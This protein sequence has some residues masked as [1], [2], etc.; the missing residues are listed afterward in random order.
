[1]FE[2]LKKS[3][4]AQQVFTDA[5]Q[6]AS[7]HL[8]A[9]YTLRAVYVHCQETGATVCHY[10][11]Y[12]KD[13]KPGRPWMS[14]DNVE[15][16][17]SDMKSNGCRYQDA[18]LFF[19]MYLARLSEV[20]QRVWTQLST[21]PHE[22]LPNVH[23]VY[24]EA[25]TES[26]DYCVTGRLVGGWRIVVRRFSDN[27]SD[28]RTKVNIFTRTCQN[29]KCTRTVFTKEPC[30]H[31]IC[32][33]CEENLTQSPTFFADFWPLH[34]QVSYIQK[35]LMRPAMTYTPP[36]LAGRT[37]VSPVPLAPPRKVPAS[38]KSKP[39]LGR[40]PNNFTRFPSPIDR[41]QGGV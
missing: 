27:A 31:L 2:K 28:K 15:R 26:K 25:N 22:L 19:D 17:N 36:N 1:M 39:T 21:H 41:F 12:D 24:K 29:P 23:D 6:A 30:K 4:H 40:R 33:L 37:L 38:A 10:R 35:V 20:Y 3:E 16:I 18:L 9:S 5:E 13:G 11:L 34:Y 32:A 14:S 8:E 7:P